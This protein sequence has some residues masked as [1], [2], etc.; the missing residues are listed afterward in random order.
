M[1]LDG[2]LLTLPIDRNELST[3]ALMIGFVDTLTGRFINS[4]KDSFQHS[5]D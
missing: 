3:V 2:A 5:D 4:P 1:T